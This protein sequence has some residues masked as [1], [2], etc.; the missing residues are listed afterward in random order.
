MVFLTGA[1]LMPCSAKFVSLPHIAASPKESLHFPTFTTIDSGNFTQIV[2]Y[3]IC[4]NHH[5]GAI[6]PCGMWMLNTFIQRT[7]ASTFDALIGISLTFT[8][9][10]HYEDLNDVFTNLLILMIVIM[11]VCW[12]CGL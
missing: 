6:I 10:S 2:K 11:M 3:N 5:K 12:S 8:H 1:K 9:F 7:F 4:K